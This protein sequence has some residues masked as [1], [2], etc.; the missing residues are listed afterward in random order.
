MVSFSFV[1][2]KYGIWLLKLTRGSLKGK[3]T[4]FRMSGSRHID[5]IVLLRRR[6]K[7]SLT[8]VINIPFFSRFSEMYLRGLIHKFPTLAVLQCQAYFQERFREIPSIFTND[9]PSLRSDINAFNKH[10]ILLRCQNLLYHNNQHPSFIVT[11]NRE[12]LNIVLRLNVF[13]RD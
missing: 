2:C 7:K 6:K 10:P 4:A 9:I 5:S 1:D 3:Q 13:I 11:I 8:Q 12:K